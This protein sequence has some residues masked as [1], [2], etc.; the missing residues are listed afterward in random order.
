M[1]NELITWVLNT[2]LGK[3]LEDFNPAQL[4]IALMSGEVELENVPIRRDALRS[5]GIPV[6]ALSGSI[7]RIKLQIPV[8]QFR[9][10]PWSIVIERVYG[11]FV[12]KDISEWDNEKEKDAEYAYKI[13]VLDAKEANW[14][15]DH[16][17]NTESYYSLSYSNWI[18][19]G[20]SL[21][22]NILEN[23][24]LK[25]NDV[26]LRYEDSITIP[27]FH[28][29]AGIRI[30][31]ISA[32]SC[33]SNWLPG[34]KNPAI[35]K[36][37]FKILELKD[38]QLYW[39]KLDITNACSGLSSKE[40]LDK[41]NEACKFEQHNFL[42][43]PINATL[44]FKRERCKQA[45][46]NKNR[47]RISCDVTVNQVNLSLS[48]IQYTEIVRCV[49]GLQN[50]NQLR[51]FKILRPSTS[52]LNDAKKWW[53][54]AA[55]CHGY[56][57]RSSEEKWR[58]ARENIKYMSIYKRLLINPSDNITKEERQFKIA[59][60]RNRC[61]D[62][63]NILREVC[64][65]YVCARGMS[66]R[67]RNIAHGKNIL[68]HWFPN[69]LGWYGVSDNTSS[70]AYLVNDETYKHIE[71]DILSALKDSIENETFSKRDAIFGNFT[72]ALSDVKIALKTSES[73]PEAIKLDMELKN[74]LCFIEIKP[75]LTSYRV[76][77]SLGS[78][79]LN[80]KLTQST[81][82]PYLIKPQNQESP[83]P[84]SFY[85]EF[86][87]FFSKRGTSHANEEPW[88]QLQYERS[89]PEHLSDYRLIIK[90]KS[91]DVVYNENAFKWIVSFFIQPITDVKSISHERKDR[92][93][94]SLTFFK[95]WKK[96]LVGQKDNRK[97][98]S[99]E[100]D[101][102]A[103]RIICVENFEEKNTSVVLIDFG[104]FQLFKNERSDID[105]QK[106]D[107]D[108]DVSEK[109]S[110]DELFMTPCSTPP[111]SKISLSDTPLVNP[112]IV[113]DHFL[114]RFVI[115]NDTGLEGDLHS[116]IYDKY[117]INLT[118]LQI[119]VCKN[120]ECTFACAKSSSSYHLLDKFNI[121]LH[122]ER[123][124][125][126]TIDPE[127]PSFTLFGNLNR[128][129]AHINEQ[130][131]LDCLKILSPI[132][133]DLFNP[134]EYSNVE[135][136]RVEN[137]IEGTDY[138]NTTIFQFVIGQ[139]ILEIQSREKSIAEIQIIGAKAAATKKSD[140][141]NI[142]MSVHGF[143]L[144]DAIQ[145]FG[146][147]FE[148]LIASHRYVEM[149]SVSGSIKQSEPCSPTSPSS[150]DPNGCQRCASP[151]IINRALNEL[152]TGLNS[153]VN[154]DDAL[155]TV[156]Y[157]I[158]HSL[159]EP[160]Q[161]A[162]IT[163]NNLD[164]IANQE[165]I[166]EL[167]GF[168][169]RILD[170]YRLFRNVTNKNERFNYTSQTTDTR[171]IGKMKSEISFDFHRLNILV[172]RS[173]RLDAL[174]VGRKVG[175]LTMSEA[176]IHATIKNEICVSGALG[177][178]QV[179][180]I[181]PEGYHHQRIF[182]VGKDPLTDPPSHYTN[183]ILFTLTNE[184]YGNDFDDDYMY[185]NALSF[186]ISQS[187]GSAVEVKIRMA[188][189]WY[190]HCP[191][192]IEEIYL[193][194]K[195]FKQ[196]FKNF[197]KSIRNKASHMAKGLVHH[198][199]SSSL[200]TNLNTFG[201]ISIDIILSSPVL[202]LP[203]SCQSNEVLVANLGKFTV[204]N[205]KDN[206]VLNS[207]ATKALDHS[208]RI[209]Y[210]IDVR[211]I[212]LFS[213]STDKRKNIG[214][215]TLPKANEIYSCH[216]GAI[217]ILHDTALLFQCVY[218]CKPFLHQNCR[219]SKYTLLVDGSVTQN[220]QVSLSKYQYEQLIESLNYAT[221]ILLAREIH[222]SNDDTI[223]PDKT[224]NL[225][226]PTISE[227]FQ[228]ISAQFSVPILK[229][230]LRNEHKVSLIHLTLEEFAFKHILVSGKQKELEILL[231]SV[232]MEDLKCPVTSK[233][234]KM[235]NSST[236]ISELQQVFG[237]KK[238]SSCS[239]LTKNNNLCACKGYGSMPSNLNKMTN[240]STINT[241]RNFNSLK[242]IDNIHII[243]RK[244]STENLVIYRSITKHPSHVGDI[245][246]VASSI[247]FNCLNLIISI[248][249]WFM[250]FDFFGL[251]SC[252]PE[253][254][255]PSVKSQQNDNCS[256]IKEFLVTIRSL[257]LILVRNESE[258]SKANV[259]NVQLHINRH[260]SLQ[261]IEGRLGSISIYDL[262]PFGHIYQE[263]FS[264]S[265]M[266]ALSFAYKRLNSGMPEPENSS[267]TL[268]KDAQLVINMSSVKY[269][270]T[271]RFIIEL[272]LF[273]KEL[274]QLQSPVM[275]RIKYNSTG[276]K[277]R[278]NRSQKIGL[279][280]HADSPIILLP[281]SYNSNHMLIADLGK[282]TLRNCFKFSNDIIGLDIPRTTVSESNEIIDLMNVDLVNIN[283]L[284]G[285]RE[286]KSVARTS[287][288]IEK[289]LFA[290]NFCIVK[291]GDTIFKETCHLKIQVM[292]NTESDISHNSPDISVKGTIS[293]LNGLINLQQYKL[294]RGFLNYNLGETIDDVYYN[295]KMNLNES[296]E[297][298]SSMSK[299]NVSQNVSSVWNTLSIHFI[300]DNVTI[301]LAEPIAKQ[302]YK[303]GYTNLAC[304]KFVKSNLEI[305]SF[306]DGSQDI[307]LIS[308]EILLVD[309]REN[310]LVMAEYNHFKDILKPSDDISSTNTVQAE[311][312]SR[313][314]NGFSKYTILLNNMRIM[315]LL[316]YL[317]RLKNFLNEEPYMSTTLEDSYKT[318][319]RISTTTN[320]I[321]HH[322][323]TKGLVSS[324]DSAKYEFV[325]NITNSEIVFVEDSSQH[326][327]NAIILKST[328]VFSYKPNSKVV[329]ISIDINH[330]EIFSCIL[331]CENESS[332][333][334]IDPFTLN[335]EL[336]N[337][338]LQ[339]SVQNQIFLRVSYNDVMLFSR[340]M[341][342]IPKQTVNAA[343]QS[344]ILE[345]AELFA[346]LITM[347]FKPSDCLVAMQI[348]NNNINE[349]AIWLS[350]QKFKSSNTFLK[351]SSMTFN[352]NSLSICIIDD[353]L[354][355]DV[356]LLELSLLHLKIDQKFDNLIDTNLVKYYEG[357]VE[358]VMSSSYYN[359]HLSGW[360]PIIEAWESVAN[361][362]YSKSNSNHLNSLDVAVNSKQIMKF[363]ITTTLIELTELVRKNWTE[364][365]FVR[366]SSYETVN[367]RQR[368]PFVPF[369]LKNLTGE[370]LIF[371]IFF[372]HAGGITRTEVTQQDL[373]CNWISVQH[374]ETVP[375]DFGPQ[376][377][378]RHLDS[379]K[380]NMHQ[381]LVQIHGWTLIGPISID[382]VG[383]FFRYAN[384][385]M[386]YSKKT[387]I[388][389]EISLIG[390]AQKLITVR[391]ALNAV[392]NTNKHFFLHLKIRN[393][394]ESAVMSVNPHQT[395]TIP[396]R[397]VESLIYI[398]PYAENDPMNKIYGALK[399][400]VNGSFKKYQLQ[401]FEET[402]F[403]TR[404]LSWQNCIALDSVQDIHSCFLPNKVPFF[405]I[406]EI[407]KDKY[408]TRDGGSLPGHTI[409]ILPPLKLKNLL[410]CDIL[411]KISGHTEGR[412][413]ASMEIEIYSIDIKESFCLCLTLDNY[414]LSGQI[415]IPMSHSGIVEPKI[416]L[417]D[418]LNRELFLRVSI[419]SF[420]GKG[421]EIY[422]GA[423]IWIIN[424][425]GLP[426]IFR[427]E[428]TSQLA[429]GQFE[430]H[431]HA[432]E[433]SPLLFSF[434]DQ[435]GSP[436]LEFRLGKS[437]GENNPWCKSFGIHKETTFRELKAEKS[438]TNYVIGV[439]V[440]RGKGL[441][442]ST[443]F[444]TLTPRF[445]LYNRSSRELYFA[446]KCDIQ[447]QLTTTPRN[448]IS[449]L[450]GSNFPFHWSNCEE[451][452]LLCVRVADDEYCHWSNGLPVNDAK[453]LYIN[454][455]N[456][457]GEMIFLRL[458]VIMHGGTYILNFTD[459]HKLPPP[460]RIDNY[461]E[462]NIHFSQK[463]IEPFWRT[464][465]KPQSSLA[466][467]LDDPLGLQV[468][469]IEAPG[470]N[471]I[472]YPL[473]KTNVAKSITYANFIY[474]AFKET[475]RYVISDC[476]DTDV[477]I[478]GQQFVLGV[479]D[480][481]VIITRKCTG[482]RSQLWLMNSYGQLEHE[483]SSPPSEYFKSTHTSPRL[484]LDLEKP[485]NPMEYTKLVVRPQNN[486]RVTTQTW[487]FENGRLMCHANMCVQAPNGLYGLKPGS[488]AV[489]GRIE[490][491]SRA[492]N[493]N[494]IPFE[495]CIEIQK[496]RPGS[497]HLEVVSKMDGPIKSVQVHD[498]KSNPDEIILAADPIWKH[499]SVFNKI[500]IEDT[501]KTGL[502]EIQIKL[503]LSKGVGLSVVTRSPSEEIAYLTFENIVVDIML[504]PFTKSIDLKVGDLQI[505]NQLLETA[506]PIMFYIPKS[507]T[508]STSKDAIAFKAKVLPSPN[509]NAVIFEHLS[510]H[511][512]PCAIL[513]EE[514][515]ILKT[516]I[517]L[518]YGRNS[519]TPPQQ[520][521][522]IVYRLDEYPFSKNAKRYYF[523]N[524]ILGATQVRLTVLTAPKLSPELL[525]IKKILGLTLIKFE[526]AIIEF[527]KFSDR[528]HFETL[529][530]YLKA[531]KVHFVNQLK[532]HAASILGSVDFLGNPLGFANDLS[533]GVSGL[534]FEGSVK[535]LVKNVT[536][537]ISNSTAKLTE[538][539]SD[540]L[541]RVVLDERDNETRQK[542]LEVSYPTTGGHLAAGLKGFGFGLLG[543]VTSIVR[544]TYVGAQADGFPGFLS[545][546]GKGLVGTVTKPLIGVLDL[547][548]ETASAVRETSRGSHHYLPDRKRL[549]RCVT[550]APGGLLP[551]Y[552]FRQSKGQQYLYIINRRNFTEKLIFY[553]PNLCNDREAKLRLL[554][555]T[556]FIRIFS[557]CEEDPA[558]MIECHLSEVLSC[559]PLTTT[560]S[561][562]NSTKIVPIYYIEISTNLPKVTRPRVRCQNEEIAE[563]AS[564]CIN[565]AKAIFDERE[566]S[567]TNN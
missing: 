195:E 333:S 129:V 277:N 367:I 251:I 132:T 258:L 164:V 341:E 357:K 55:E 202:V 272:H 262:T 328:T 41:M 249:K 345:N 177:G 228:K 346:P 451:E 363:N 74:L 242:N 323:P 329:P 419:Q 186:K 486:Q 304:I 256:S 226:N 203:R 511:M 507:S 368:N 79:H 104:R 209:T 314:R 231:R 128:I 454:L 232:V 131:I 293:E 420:P 388:V 56:V 145:S 532:W 273:V 130:K 137:N 512:K 443:T 548:S 448:H 49:N 426:L 114:S 179:V 495:Q 305:D 290:G 355:A 184:M 439:N 163:F 183:D 488:D 219:E 462:V 110:D 366:S 24:E 398:K 492:I 382:K 480:K 16:G 90:S 301:Y 409:Q 564:R 23:L 22:T 250:V 545:G 567:L 506:S 153:D 37:L 71:D 159:E 245:D 478:E 484:V 563:R 295:Y 15:V 176:K 517:F 223:I 379:H 61:I 147:D 222:T 284:T 503:N 428:G 275:N 499:A 468:L 458:E 150:P 199:S 497:G 268:E 543:G 374:N 146:P 530:I 469:R 193:C 445:Q 308:T 44:K 349:A 243:T 111:G 424:K 134:V 118:D 77:I 106:T 160:M 490:S 218:E 221:N 380:L 64:C 261:S 477:G 127:Y 241:K 413:D 9:T 330:L 444:I 58:I 459:A 210:Y 319:M 265:G 257:N 310:D 536:H 7:G 59:T 463:G 178:I 339:I 154:G 433:V 75:K 415:K 283:L 246:V 449:A 264:T 171:S 327:S 35:Q 427:Q 269:I 326:D 276:E 17:C 57:V 423:P 140:A 526:D 285:E 348:N 502:A 205:K 69:W 456:D 460:I 338:C 384:L 401:Q 496:L 542:I 479:K 149:D 194:V 455:R 360:E 84:K 485:P 529:D 441:Y 408:P 86:L 230:D 192:F 227:S 539:I 91:L 81:E 554:V 390:S 102:S 274:L 475:F 109:E 5:F 117:I 123:R 103:P 372:S 312:H 72:F 365:F 561:T 279:E 229:L 299:V 429:S 521:E 99:F 135:E 139:I 278:K 440:Q 85:N 369:A 510:V 239:D 280:V 406:S 466:Y 404:S 259:S 142:S 317:E 63:L 393:E 394:H 52:V 297:I 62:D 21:V 217:P 555:S 188:S 491:S 182:S 340:M 550:G 472:E 253:R 331:G 313:K 240:A 45:L 552:S 562:A 53:R 320:P 376:S 344:N 531:V 414:R 311:I 347:G 211:N 263:K 565:Y 180:D 151:H 42:T 397:Y 215:K 306:S 67:H 431:E 476:E 325:L 359:R 291:L 438:K 60:E 73:H 501:K 136:T 364:D 383:T 494:S 173:T 436:L 51:N 267:R 10:S 181:T 26:H 119:L 540:S 553:E 36:V 204:C 185:L 121:N 28:H 481:R 158:I 270:H 19:Y 172:L 350:Q 287:N 98:W 483:G 407:I 500:I 238:S 286:T 166:V 92:E 430:E 39:D 208:E 14:R 1:L 78:I 392:N 527:D 30:N 244:E 473:N 421:M 356:P 315:A 27:H 108:V 324:D 248:D 432:R 343:K 336:R 335:M 115:N 375:F 112:A 6:E 514:R 535:S 13:R 556:E 493:E 471:C 402:G 377:K 105:H 175:T 332:L 206:L 373:M 396:L 260:I 220:L 116:E 148:L 422:I 54:Y 3:Y 125:I 88:F 387:R 141:V 216:D 152:Q 94:Y 411:Y 296:L 362:K 353:C 40:L 213:L 157:N 509:K 498:V 417:I 391:S 82:F 101:I 50:I 470:G 516:A 523:E 46:R 207:G 100:I 126:N 68:Y 25:I 528:H 70:D 300:L 289:I 416:K 525:E 418:I 156:D 318:N 247:D 361:W 453:S 358:T 378:L 302:N 113:N 446:Q 547:A 321:Q 11:V 65:D 522:S 254:D 307:D 298:L 520:T 198:I 12:P 235:V 48:D 95:N 342:S 66:T 534:I 410:C 386:Q 281:V 138:D 212:N 89:P 403:C 80:D 2:Y 144:V 354:D 457:V 83:N 187:E 337:N 370:P 371:K 482:D 385:D 519:N 549:P 8:R 225:N 234:R 395:V 191:R 351:V 400:D 474:I 96:V 452:P 405:V 31:S 381:I 200:E 224:E 294:I 20:T 47:P 518:G 566:H 236:D 29:A 124:I 34:A 282:I 303:N 122:L 515:L 143:L 18:N 189:V 412:I 292:R 107:L 32:Q 334:I 120:R 544:H 155:I 508:E 266:E 161:I 170:N 538:T 4:S 558:I 214:A 309:A 467:V 551:N 425:T 38:F 316:D 233:Y 533:E 505:D 252:Q 165:T 537:G 541:G 461:S 557:R 450:P 442:L 489:L 399:N 255:E 33:D 524:L 434:S 167:L 133:L 93:I 162:N 504:S 43:N 513:L 465:V 437:Y 447:Q 196:Y 288:E 76:G 97:K 435:E 168:G 87:N 201:D 237:Y 190:T 464:S 322:I 174:N 560:T 271:K 559:H 169:K 487:R 197:L 389:F 352:A 546:L